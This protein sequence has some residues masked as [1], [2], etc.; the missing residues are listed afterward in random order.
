MSRLSR[1]TKTN[2]LANCSRQLLLVSQHFVVKLHLPSLPIP[3]DIAI[4]PSPGPLL[5]LLF[6]AWH[7]VLILYYYNEIKILL[8]ELGGLFN[9]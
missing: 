1:R 9:N 4:P 3:Y 7:S 6:T 8:T 5:L 2:K